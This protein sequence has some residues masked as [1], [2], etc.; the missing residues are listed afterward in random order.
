MLVCLQIGF[1]Y[2]VSTLL[3]FKY[4]KAKLAAIA[5]SVKQFWQCVPF[6]SKWIL[7]RKLKAREVFVFSSS[8]Q[9]SY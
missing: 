9:L 8:N 4:Q 6:D 3:L 7:I 5:K 1:I 2:P